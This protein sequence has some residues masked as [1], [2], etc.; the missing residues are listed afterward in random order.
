LTYEN[1]KA[2]VDLPSP[3]GSSKNEIDGFGLG[4]RFGFH[5]ANSTQTVDFIN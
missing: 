3:F 1:G 4:A 5:F 2:G